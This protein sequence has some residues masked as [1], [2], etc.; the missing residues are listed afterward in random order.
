MCFTQS[1]L[2]RCRDFS[3]QE[4]LPDMSSH[5]GPP[6]GSPARGPG[7]CVSY[8]QAFE[9]SDVSVLPRTGTLRPQ[10][11]PSSKVPSVSECQDQA[12]SGAWASWVS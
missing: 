8:S 1:R 4:F 6:L 10:G 11:P 2:P 12:D 5:A 7:R 3:P 9:M